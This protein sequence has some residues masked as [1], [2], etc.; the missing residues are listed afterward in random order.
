M[1]RP[2]SG[3]RPKSKFRSRPVTTASPLLSSG[4]CSELNSS[5]LSL[6]LLGAPPLGNTLGLALAFAFGSSRYTHDRARS[7]L[8]HD[9][10]GNWASQRFL[11]SLQGTQAR[12]ERLRSSGRTRG[13]GMIDYKQ[14]C[15][16]A[17]ISVFDEDV[18]VFGRYQFGDGRRFRWQ[19]GGRAPS[20]AGFPTGHGEHGP[21]LR[22][23]TAEG[24]HSHG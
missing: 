8:K 19:K 6:D 16:V 13:R 20:S 12:D 5:D 15:L 23:R 2:I 7:R 22:G 4:G 18:F 24:G 3:I 1:G 21:G 11:D 10:Q 9:A 17:S 14:S